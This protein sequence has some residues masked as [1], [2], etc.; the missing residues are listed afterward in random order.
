MKIRTKLAVLISGSIFF[1]IL[2]TA[3]GFLQLQRKALRQSEAEKKRL[4]LESVSQSA[5]ESLLAKDPLMLLDAL[6][7]LVQQRDEVH[8]AKVRVGDRFEDVG[9]A[10]PPPPPG[11]VR[12][13]LIE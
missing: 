6:A 9:G 8:H 11:G 10:A 12:E 7:A 5:R 4:L 13:E 3:G 1:A 2:A